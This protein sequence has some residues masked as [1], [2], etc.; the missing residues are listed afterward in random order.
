MIS[1]YHKSTYFFKRSTYKEPF[2]T[3]NKIEVISNRQMAA[4]I[5]IIKSSR[6]GSGEASSADRTQ[7]ASKL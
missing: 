1:K 3:Y 7:S 5:R 2:K 6:L 4:I